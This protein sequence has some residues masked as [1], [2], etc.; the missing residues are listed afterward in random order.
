MLPGDPLLRHA[1]CSS[2]R[3]DPGSGDWKQVGEGAAIIEGRLENLRALAALLIQNLRI[4]RNISRLTRSTGWQFCLDE[5]IVYRFTEPEPNS[6]ES[7]TVRSQLDR[8]LG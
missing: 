8:H 4:H 6:L 1:G 5:D 7:L 3:S 2:A